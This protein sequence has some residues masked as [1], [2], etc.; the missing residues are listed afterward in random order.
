VH[1]SYGLD[2]GQDTAAARFFILFIGIYF[3]LLGLLIGLSVRVLI[4]SQ[5]AWESVQNLI[6]KSVWAKHKSGFEARD[7]SPVTMT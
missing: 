3:D 7:Q 5:C 1:R 2:G 4:K 6:L